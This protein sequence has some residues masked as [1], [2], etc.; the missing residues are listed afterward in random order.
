MSKL[1]TIIKWGIVAAS[2][3]GGWQYYQ[4]YLDSSAA[5]IGGRQAMEKGR[6]D[7]AVEQLQTAYE[8][9]P[10]DL[11]ICLD[12]AECTARL[13]QDRDALIWYRRAEPLLARD[14]SSISMQR[15]KER[16]ALLCQKNDW[17][18]GTVPDRSPHRRPTP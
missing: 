11:T 5:L 14:S 8:Q 7:V 17:N 1:G 18:A 15:H 4:Q 16:F 13:G 2:L 12:L 3:A 6:Y 10:D 9:D